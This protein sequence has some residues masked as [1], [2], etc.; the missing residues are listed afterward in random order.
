MNENMPLSLT[1]TILWIIPENLI[2]FPLPFLY[3]AAPF[4]EVIA[5]I[6]RDW[7]IARRQLMTGSDHGMLR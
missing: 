6:V 5:V 2:I 7:L 3:S 4:A 1:E